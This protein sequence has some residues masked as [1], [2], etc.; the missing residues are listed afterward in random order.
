M[1]FQT[2]YS[3]VSSKSVVAV[4]EYEIVIKSAYFDVTPG[5]TSYINIPLIIRNDVEQESKNAYIWHKLWMKK[6]PTAADNACDGYSVKQINILSK[7]ADL[8]SGKNYDTLE[9]WMADLIRR[10]M[11]VTVE[12]EEYNG[13][14]QVKVK[15]T[16][17]TRK[18][19]MQHSFKESSLPEGAIQDGQIPDGFQAIEDD[20]IPF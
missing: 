4:G 12:H 9:M 20:D 8:P 11:R 1:G 19:D 10:P 16:N 5:G 18:K 2:N 7:A 15:Y 6:E 17:E 13:A 3:D 14:T